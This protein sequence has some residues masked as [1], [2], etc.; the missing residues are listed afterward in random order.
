MWEEDNSK[1]WDLHELGIFLNLP[2]APGFKSSIQPFFGRSKI[3]KHL[4]HL[5]KNHDM[6]NSRKREFVKFYFNHYQVVSA[7]KTRKKIFFGSNRTSF[8]AAHWSA[9]SSIFLKLAVIDREMNG[10]DFESFIV[11]IRWEKHLHF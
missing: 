2:A 5:S 1:L 7:W 4:F 8:F 6:C 3:P 10:G 9:I 11:K